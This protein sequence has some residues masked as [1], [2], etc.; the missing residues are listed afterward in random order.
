[1][2][3]FPKLSVLSTQ[4]I[5]YL[6]D[7]RRDRLGHLL[8]GFNDIRNVLEINNVIRSDLQLLFPGKSHSELRPLQ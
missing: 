4:S 5:I 8:I 6:K 7:I 2:Q 1:M 3:I